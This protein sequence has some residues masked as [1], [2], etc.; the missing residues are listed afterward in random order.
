[1][2]NNTLMIQVTKVLKKARSLISKEESWVKNY[3]A[4][5][6]FGHAIPP[7]NDSAVCW[8]ASGAIDRA[9]YLSDEANHSI[10]YANCL[11]F[12]KIHG[13]WGYYTLSIYN[14]DPVTTH[15]DI[16]SLFDKAIEKSSAR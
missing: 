13:S 6:E 5:D 4:K 9:A 16:L 8:C 7:I 11:R 14:D 3:T 10:I 1:M 15:G 2:D 12:M